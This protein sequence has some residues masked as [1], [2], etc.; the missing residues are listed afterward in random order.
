MN[1]TY[2]KALLQELIDE[3]PF[4]VRAVLK[5]LGVVFTDTV[6][7]L[8]VT[9]EKSPRLLVNLEFLQE[10]CQTEKQVKAVIVHEFLHILLGHTEDK[11]AMTPA[12]HL[13]FDAVIN[14][15]IHRQYGWEY[16]AMMSSYYE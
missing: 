14:A 9:R 7:T 11:K 6:P 12:R 4:S 15:I 2:F 8:A 5:I 3:N 16:S 13:A 10:H 1:E